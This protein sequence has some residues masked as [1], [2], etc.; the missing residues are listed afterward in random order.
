M[1]VEVIPDGAILATV[2]T[3]SGILDYMAFQ[4][5][6]L[7]IHF[8]ENDWNDIDVRSGRS[9]R[10]NDGKQYS[11]YIWWAPDSSKAV[12][13][14]YFYIYEHEE[15]K[16]MDMTKEEALKKIEELK[17]YVEQW[18]EK[19]IPKMQTNCLRDINQCQIKAGACSNFNRYIT[20][21]NQDTNAIWAIMSIEL[22]HLLYCREY[23]G[24]ESLQADQDADDVYRLVYNVYSGCYKVN[25]YGCVDPCED[26]IMWFFKNYKDAQR[27]CDYMNKYV[28]DVKRNMY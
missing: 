10:M 24:V 28:K 26:E 22:A 4:T 8:I 16:K 23:L 21:Q 27:V 19:E 17:A 13:K 18:D 14:M 11:L 5:M 1:G 9:N 7:D 3:F 6:F 25:H 2:T 15:E 20:F 12:A